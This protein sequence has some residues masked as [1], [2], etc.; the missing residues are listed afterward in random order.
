MKFRFL[1]LALFIP[2]MA[3]TAIGGYLGILKGTPSIAELREDNVPGTKI[4]ADD[5]S[6]LAELSSHKSIHVPLRKIPENLQDAV[7]AVEDSRFYKHGGIDYI[8]IIRAAFVDIIHGQIREGG[9]TITQQL[10]KITFLSPKRT[11]K[12]KIR[13]AALAMKIEKQLTKQEILELY[14]NRVYFGHGAYGVEM[15]SRLYFGKPVE[16]LTL[17][18]AALIAGL[19]RG[20][21]EFSPFGNPKKCKERQ[22]V[23]LDRM[24]KEKY[25]TKAQ[26]LAAAKAPIRLSTERP[27]SEANQYF[28]DYIKK[29]LIDKYGAKKVYSGK[30]RV[31]TTLQ[32]DL[33]AQAQTDLRQG[34]MDVD[35]RR[36]WRGPVGHVDNYKQTGKPGL[37]L[38]LE[39]ANRELIDGTVIKLSPK[40]AVL[41]LGGRTGTL[42]IKD[43]MWA[44]R[45]IDRNG[46]TRIIKHFTLEKILH[47][48]DVITVGVK[49]VTAR[50]YQVVLDQ[51]PTVEGALV[52][53]D[54]KTGFIRALVGGDDYLSSEYDRAL[55]A[56]RQAGSSFKP[57]YYAAA[58][59]NGFTPS[60][61]IN[62]APITFS[63]AGGSWS[64]H[65]YEN[66]FWG[67]T[68][69]RMALAHS[70][71]VVSVKLLDKLGVDKAIDFARQDGITEPMPKDLTLALGS[72]S[73]T[74]LDLVTAYAPFANTGYKVTPIAIK[75]I[76][77]ENG[78][79]LE[80]NDPQ[81]QRVLS[82]ETSFLM[83]SM[84][85]DVIRYG[86]GYKARVL[87]DN[88]A[89]KTGT[90][91]D[92]RDAW[93]I[94]FN[95]DLLAGVWVGFDNMS[96][97]GYGETGAVAACPIWTNFMRYVAQKSPGDKFEA[98]PDDMIE[99][100]VDAQTGQI[101]PPGAQPQG[102]VYEEYF[103]KDAPPQGTMLNPMI[104][105]GGSVSNDVD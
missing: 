51:Q 62:D 94:G 93:F 71:N 104:Q 23:V 70:R 82:P 38:S 18:E 77:D 59:E 103:K 46:K 1:A 69:L 99:Y 20:P 60:S 78:R 44:Q 100:I 86:T 73:I 36:G 28:V 19:I 102:P 65:N 105:G 11:F 2:L 66:D 21:G 49:S 55:Y 67:P 96:P 6:L 14:L 34:L 48:G 84:L 68:S 31:Y 5:D 90:T 53:V 76:T 50:G 26:M 75:Y 29:Y 22:L 9:S 3:G 33:Q 80:S 13:E 88:V 74:P 72:L 43:A 27:P 41:D 32:R 39:P 24:Y 37:A 56:H 16:R 64:P 7:I 45:V 81:T 95:P 85:Q 17:P 97:L 89:G 25:I 83:T 101:L 79:I 40:V 47:L 61:V 91:S 54:P 52:A 87:G 57:I 98:P 4:Y 8:G 12:R 35:K 15:A 10:A 63:W 30:L 58:L 42:S 92:Y